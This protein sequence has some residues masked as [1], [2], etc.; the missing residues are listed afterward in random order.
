MQR[1]WRK[2]GWAGVVVALCA[3]RASGQALPAELAS[4]WHQTGMPQS[5]MSLVV[6]EVGGPRLAAVNAR[7]PRNPASVMKLV[8]TW[9]ALSELGPSYK[10]TTDLVSNPGAAIVNGVLSGPLYVRAAGDP[11]LMLQDL[12]TLLRD[13]RLQGVRQIGDVVVDRSIFGNVA[14]DPGAFDNAPD[15]AYNASPDAFMVGFGAQRLMFTADAATHA[16]RVVM[17]PPLPNVKLDGKLDWSDAACRG[18]YEVYTTPVVTPQD[19]TFKLSGTVPGA[20]GDFSLYRLAL[21]QPAQTSGVLRELWKE[22]GGTMTGQVRDGLAPVDG[23]VLA[24]HASP[25]LSDVIRIINKHS[26]NV[27][28]RTL[29]LTLGAERGLRP[30]TVASSDAVASRLLADQGLSMPDLVLGNGA[31]LSRRA[32]VSADDLAALLT[33]AWKSPYMPEFVS[34][35]A[36]L[37]EDGTVKKRLRHDEA[38]GRAHLK[39]GTLRDVRAMAGYVTGAS[40]KRYIVVCLVNNEKADEKAGAL[41]YFD[42]AL[43]AWLAQR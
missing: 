31:G 7:V 4:A 27:M 6:Q 17:D 40:G 25:E 12:W 2:S 15:R 14:T 21:P 41:R 29:L 30:A 36:I 39:T 3:A 43:V 26:N 33:A 8:T 22:L 1:I 9:T 37:G 34:S 18:E 11:D 24:S 5:S 38:T 32:R 10:W 35:L 13:L 16:W 42:N 23:T 19:T 20:C 28:A